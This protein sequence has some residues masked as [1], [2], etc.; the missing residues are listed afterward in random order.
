VSQ[1]YAEIDHLHKGGLLVLSEVPDGRLSI[2][3]NSVCLHSIVVLV[4]SRV[5][6]L[7]ASPYHLVVKRTPGHVAHAVVHLLALV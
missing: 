6:I 4:K 2:S 5:E 7:R 1:P 3:L